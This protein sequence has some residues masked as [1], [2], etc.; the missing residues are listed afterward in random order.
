[1]NVLVTG[2]AGF[3]GSHLVERLLGEGNTVSVID[4]LSTGSLDNLATLHNHPDLTFIRGDIRDGELVQI[5]V[6]EADVVFHLAAAVGVQLIAQ[7]PVRT[8]ETNIGGTETVL[9][10]ANR[11]GKKIF[12]V[13]PFTHK[14]GKVVYIHNI[15]GV[16]IEIGDVADGRE[17]HACFRCSAVS[18]HIYP[19]AVWPQFFGPVRS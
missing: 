12:L 15:A 14:H 18:T 1:M 7:D 8:I 9:E 4:N 2:G 11:F 16:V 13:T 19:F 3:I 6:K 5:M 10:K 17:R